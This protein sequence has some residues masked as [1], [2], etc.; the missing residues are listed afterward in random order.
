VQVKDVRH[1]EWDDVVEA[2]EKCYELGWTDGLPVVPPTV[3]RVEAFIEYGRRAP[4]EVLGTLPERRRAITVAKVAANAVMAGCKPEYCP[5]LLAATEAM[6][7]PAFNLI[8]PSSSQGSAAVLTIVNGPIARKLQI[9]CRNNL[10]GPGHRANAT[11]GR[12]IRLILM[13]ACASIRVSGRNR[14]KAYGKGY[15]SSVMHHI[16]NFPEKKSLRESSG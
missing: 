15:D 8:G 13:N 4:D 5:V 1:V 7:D 11:I 10:F 14:S 2:I 3:E 9:N 12:A 16:S 6:L